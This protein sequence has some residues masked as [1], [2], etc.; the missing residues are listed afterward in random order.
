MFCKFVYDLATE[1]SKRIILL[2]SDDIESKSDLLA[3][4]RS[5]GFT[6][7]EYLDD[8]ELRVAHNEAIYGDTENILLAVKDGRYIPYDILRRFRVV[9]ISLASLF[10][11]LD[12]TAIKE[13]CDI[14]LDLL[15]LA[16]R[17]SYANLDYSATKRF[18]AEIVYG[19]K[20]MEDYVQE[21][22]AELREAIDA[23][24]NYKD[25]FR[26]ANLKAQID[27]IATEY[28]INTEIG[29]IQSRFI[30]YVLSNY[31][32][33]STV[34]DRK[35]PVL[36]SRAM[37]YMH[38][39]SEK[40]AVIVMDGMSEFDWHIISRTFSEIRYT[41]SDAFAMI[42]TTTSISRQCLLSNKYPSQLVEPW[43]QSKERAEFVE[44]ALNLGF[45]QE[46]IEYERG[47]NAEIG[48]AAK[49]VAI[50][51][52]DVDDMVHG[53]MQGR[54]GMFNDISVLARGGELL[55]LVKRLLAQKFDVYITA[56]HGNVPCTGMGKLMSTGVEVETKSRRMLVLKDFADKQALIQKY[57]LIEFPKYYL[58]KDFDYLICGPEG[59]FD[60]KGEKVMSHGGITVD[61]VIVPF[62]QI[63]AVEN[64][65]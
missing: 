18:I 1:Y 50:I 23:A 33:L 44:C 39:N 47:Y 25:W 22:T 42:P 41:K 6:V 48:F 26:I 3:Y 19:R 59:S 16:Y 17:N 14:D 53:Q 52:N 55:A 65:G 31:G 27:V 7:I 61:E 28:D 40:F 9:N 12:T 8:L 24:S 38:D 57:G 32:K 2:D 29:D 63:K 43:R 34:M 37:E 11:R 30:S 36:V 15:H 5:S 46:Q 56:D 10:P 62:I 54:V 20:N 4:F 60:A 51:V 58:N 13:R 45:N 35:G 64:N 21:R 49:C